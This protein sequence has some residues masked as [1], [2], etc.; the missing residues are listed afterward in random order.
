M[1]A[2]ASATGRNG[3]RDRTGS[4]T[5]RVPWRRLAWITWRQHRAALGWML[6]VFAVTAVL[7]AVTYGVPA[8]SG[9]HVFLPSRSVALAINAWKILAQLLPVLAG[10]FLGAPLLARESEHGTARLAWTQEAGRTRWLVVKVVPVGAI[11]AVAA[12]GLG[13]ELRWWLAPFTASPFLWAPEYFD[14]RPLPFTGWVTLG[15]ALGVVLGA[16]IRRT[17]PAMAATLA[18]YA[19]LLY[20]TSLWWRMHYLP[21]LH[22][23][24]PHVLIGSGGS[25]DYSIPLTS[26]PGDY[27]LSAAPSWPDGRLLTAAQLSHRASWF[28]LHHIRLWVTYQPPDRYG[29]FKVIEFGWLVAAAAILIAATAVL[30]RRRAA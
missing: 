25:Y 1:T 12:A 26:R 15:F 19:A 11:L 17:V 4:T 5:G 16:V 24:L 30:I 7:L 10:V 3:R 22:R 14:L 21:P 8:R 27:V 23:P 29:L 2:T 18:C 6:L 13:L 20:V 9:D 28:R